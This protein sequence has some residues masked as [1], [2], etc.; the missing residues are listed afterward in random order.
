VT[1]EGRGTLPYD[2][3]VVGAGYVGLPLAQTFADAGRRVLVLDVVPELVQALNEGRS[4]IHDVPSERLAPHVASGR[5]AV[6]TDY[7]QLQQAK[8][9]LIALPTPLTPSRRRMRSGRC[10]SPDRSSCSSRQP[11]R[12]RRAR[13]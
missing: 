5:I 8:A 13:S 2:V 12:A 11:T 1:E 3:A 7:E 6:T 10:S 4:H 9:I